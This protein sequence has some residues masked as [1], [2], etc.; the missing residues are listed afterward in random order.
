MAL[1]ARIIERILDM[2]LPKVVTPRWLRPLA[3]HRYAR[4]FMSWCDAFGGLLFFT[5]WKLRLTCSVYEEVRE[6][7]YSRPAYG[8]HRMASKVSDQI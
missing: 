6:V 2:V 3:A 8:W 5:V 7:A 1:L 4:V